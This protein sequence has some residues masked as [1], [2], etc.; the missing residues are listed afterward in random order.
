[1]N[2]IFLL[3]FILTF[4][5]SA[6]NTDTNTTSKPPSK[7]VQGDSNPKTSQ[8]KSPTS[9]ISKA[10]KTERPEL[11]LTYLMQKPEGGIT[12]TTPLLLL[13][14]G[15]GS[16][17]KDLFRLNSYLDKRCL[18]LAVQAPMSMGAN[19]SK[20]KWYDIDF[21]EGQK[22]RNHD[23]ITTST[24]T[25]MAFIDAAVKTFNLNGKQ[26]YL[27]GF[28]QGAILSLGLATQHPEKVKGIM[29]LS[30]YLAEEFKADKAANEQLKQVSAF[31]AHGTK[32]QVI[33]IE[34]ARAGIKELKKWGLPTTYKEY[35]IGHT[36][37]GEILRDL[38]GWLSADIDARP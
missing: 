28:S 6:C 31:I 30:G 21:V 23:N 32:D 35:P 3:I 2:R 12:E 37:S 14:H 22:I 27:M 1:M 26:V 19:A 18:I 5:L 38:G 33:N 7:E 16:S 20:Y 8:Q 13:L 10:S 29:A 25:L 15:Y 4:L 34:E 24:A 9:A 36:I 17:E 11:P